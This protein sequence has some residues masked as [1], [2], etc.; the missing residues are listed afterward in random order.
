M[1]VSAYFVV[2]EVPRLELCALCCWAA[3]LSNFG[4]HWRQTGTAHSLQFS[5]RWTVWS[6]MWCSFNRSV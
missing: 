3:Y 5:S 2:F 6:W 4:C 1:A